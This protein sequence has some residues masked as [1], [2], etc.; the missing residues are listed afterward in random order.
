M[1]KKVFWLWSHCLQKVPNYSLE[2]KIW[3]SFLWARNSNS[4]DLN[5]LSTYSSKFKRVAN[6]GIALVLLI[7]MDFLQTVWYSKDFQFVTNTIFNGNYLHWETKYHYFIK[8]KRT[9]AAPSISSVK[10]LWPVIKTIKYR[11]KA[12]ILFILI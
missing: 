2:Q 4:I 7:G 5:Y 8:L 10:Q 11:F 6:I 12:N 3:I 9:I 1:A